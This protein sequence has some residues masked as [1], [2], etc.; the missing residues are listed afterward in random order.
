MANQIKTPDVHL[1]CVITTTF[2]V[3]Y[4]GQG[5]ILEQFWPHKS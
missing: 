1:H 2:A 4:F 3:K 5:T